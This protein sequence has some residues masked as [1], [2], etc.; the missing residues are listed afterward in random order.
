MTRSLAIASA[1]FL[2]VFT[3]G[4]FLQSS[5]VGSSGET[6]DFVRSRSTVADAAETVESGQDAAV[7]HPV[8][9]VRRVQGKVERRNDAGGWIPLVSGELLPANDE[10][11][12]DVNSVAVV[13]LGDSELVLPGESKV[14]LE[15]KE[16]LITG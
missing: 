1:L 2:A 12:T 4:Y 16:G 6:D 8:Y 14:T 15:E 13:K 3:G 5:L 11:R 9:R 7:A 10:I